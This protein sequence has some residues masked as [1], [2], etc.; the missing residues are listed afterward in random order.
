MN[1][2]WS[3]FPKDVGN[4]S[5][6]ITTVLFPNCVCK[7]SILWPSFIKKSKIRIMLNLIYYYL[8]IFDSLS[9]FHNQI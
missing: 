3:N 6:E 4:V 5:L 1:V 8:F 2:W 7:I 9:K